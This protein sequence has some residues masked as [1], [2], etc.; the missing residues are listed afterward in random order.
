MN[1]VPPSTI[2]LPRNSKQV[3]T[4]LWKRV[5]CCQVRVKVVTWQSFLAS[6]TCHLTGRY[7]WV[8]V[9]TWQDVLSSDS[10][11]CHL[12]EH[13]V[14]WHRICHVTGPVVNW[15]ITPTLCHLHIR[16]MAFPYIL[17][18]DIGFVSVGHI[19]GHW[20]VRIVWVFNNA[21][22][23]RR[24]GTAS[25]KTTNICKHVAMAKT[26]QPMVGSHCADVLQ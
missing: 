17:R 8:N 11:N 6:E 4:W 2:H 1:F 22:G 9:V 18:T 21:S 14:K 25:S 13:V 20:S 3:S 26:H 12:T 24:A 15:H 23:S 5:V 7:Y 16:W 10:G 19:I